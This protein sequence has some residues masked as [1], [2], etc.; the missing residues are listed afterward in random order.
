MKKV[1]YKVAVLL[2][3]GS[4]LTTSCVGSFGLF[5]KYAAWQKDLTKS[6]FVNAVVGFIMMP[7][8]S[9]IC[10]LADVL[11][12]NSIEFWSGSNP[13]AANG[14]IQKVLGRD[15]RYYAIKTTKNGYEVKDDQG[16]VTIFTHDEK[17]D[18]WSVT[19]NGETR[20]LFRYAEDGQIQAVMQSGKT[21]TI[22]QDEAGLQQ[23]RQAAW[24]ENGYALR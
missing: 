13:M 2:C 8:C 6:K 7:I 3:A 18:S 24:A 14:S 10:L 16:Q 17:S 19:Q 5:N 4:L 12:L 11:V 9:P 23:I 22:S 21:I 1:M 20:E 15:G